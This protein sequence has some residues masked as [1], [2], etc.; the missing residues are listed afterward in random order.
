MGG[1][2]RHHRSSF[3]LTPLGSVLAIALVVFAVLAIVH[4]TAGAYLGLIAVIV[5]WGVALGM[6]F[7]SGQAR[8]TGHGPE[9][10]RT[11]YGAEAA[12]EHERQSD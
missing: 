11:D 1:A 7:P 5:I 12:D 2:G 10:G 8:G 4:P 9:A 6:S 3:K